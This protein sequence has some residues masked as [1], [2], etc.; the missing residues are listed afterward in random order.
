MLNEVVQELDVKFGPA[1]EV[2]KIMLL[3]KDTGLIDV[4][5][6]AKMAPSIISLPQTYLEFNNIYLKRKCFH[7]GLHSTE[8]KLC[9]ICG[10]VLCLSGCFGEVSLGNLNKHALDNH[11]GFGLFFDR[12]DFYVEVT[13]SPLQVSGIG[14]NIYINNIGQPID[15]AVEYGESLPTLDFKKYTL[16]PQFKEEVE[17]ILKHQRIGQYLFD[18]RV[19]LGKEDEENF[20]VDGI[21]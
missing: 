1:T 6:I 17:S 7:C 10:E 12:V 8:L 4:H 9:L 21:W 20:G 11:M 16:N 18:M 5:K 2:L 15:E 13:D 19:F 14:R 3:P